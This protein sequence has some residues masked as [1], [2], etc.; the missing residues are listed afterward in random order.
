MTPLK[1]SKI[2][3]RQFILGKQGLYPGRRWQGKAG[4]YEALRAGCV[5]QMDPLSIVAHNQ[6]IAL[7]GRIL[8]YDPV[9]LKTA[10]YTDRLCFDYGGVVMLHLMEELPYWRVVMARKQREARRVE[11]AAEHA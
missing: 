1:I 3:Q 7:Y 4:I 9:D 11:F 5:V 6:D 8:D 2:T 10:L